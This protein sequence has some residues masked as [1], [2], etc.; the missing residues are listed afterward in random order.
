MSDHSPRLIYVSTNDWVCRGEEGKGGGEGRSCRISICWQQKPSQS[1]DMIDLLWFYVCCQRVANSHT[2]RQMQQSVLKKLQQSGPI[3][4]K[5]HSV[6]RD[7][8]I[9]RRNI[10]QRICMKQILMSD[11]FAPSVK[12]KK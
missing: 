9:L 3:N 7:E 5:M 10:T 2:C 12:K 11:K 4:E 1:S 6:R 8:R